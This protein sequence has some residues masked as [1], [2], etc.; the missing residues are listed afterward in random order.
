MP[1]SGVSYSRLPSKPSLVDGGGLCH[2]LLSTWF[3]HRNLARNRNMYLLFRSSLLHGSQGIAN[4]RCEKGKPLHVSHPNINTNPLPQRVGRH[5]FDDEEEATLNKDGHRLFLILFYGTLDRNMCS[6]STRTS[7]T[8]LSTPH[9]FQCIPV[10]LA[11]FD[12]KRYHLV[13]NHPR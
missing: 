13:R 2:L 4:H 1:S 12:N 11:G 8:H 5:T 6:M 3:M 9:E 7:T 10:R